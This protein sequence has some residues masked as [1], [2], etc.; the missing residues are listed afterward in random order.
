MNSMGSEGITAGQ[1][2]TSAMLD[3]RQ[4]K[5]RVLQAN[6]SLKQDFVDTVCI[7]VVIHNDEPQGRR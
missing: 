3:R 4:V 6:S 1:I 7:C 2:L 5:G